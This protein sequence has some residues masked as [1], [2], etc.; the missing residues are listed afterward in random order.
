MV[1]PTRSASID[2]MSRLPHELA[3]RIMALL[4]LED[5]LAAQL[6]S[7]RWH[8]IASEPAVWH[9]LVLQQ[10]WHFVLVI[11]TSWR[12]LYMDRFELERRWRMETFVCGSIKSFRPK[13]NTLTGHTG[14]IYCIASDKHNIPEPG[15]ILSGSRDNTIKVWNDG[16]CE[17]QLIGHSG[18]VLSIAAQNGMV[19]SG[20]SDTTVRIW[21]QVGSEYTLENVLQSHTL[22]VLAVVFDDTYIASSSRDR[23]VRVWGHDGALKYVYSEHSSSVNACSICAR[24]V[25]SGGGDGRIF[26]FELATGSTVAALEGPRCGI[27]SI[28]YDGEHV[29]TG[30]SDGCVRIW[31][32]ALGIP[33]ATFPAHTGLV[34]AL[35]YNPVRQLLVT[36][37]WDGCMRLWDLRN[38]LQQRGNAFLLLDHSGHNRI[39]A[40]HM[41]AARVVSGGEGRAA[42]ITDFGHALA[43]AVR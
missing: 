7:R 15:V 8:G 31:S 24:C 20:S 9:A 19:V 30:S 27:A 12:A 28:A 6:V 29:I 43:P 34:R 26:I 16:H 5:V 2:Y 39:F 1:V 17:Q 36:G 14:S 10:G 42:C 18:S 25:A 35:S 38:V 41:D 13:I 11:G 40:T 3:V 37:G 33:I 32:V 22:G 4:A 23:T 21:R